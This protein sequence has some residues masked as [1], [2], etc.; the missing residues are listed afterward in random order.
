MESTVKVSEESKDLIVILKT[1]NEAYDA[2]GEYIDKY[3]G[4]D[5][6]SIRPI[7]DDFYSKWCEVVGVVENCLSSAMIQNLRDTNFGSI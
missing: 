2:F 6:T 4:K 5:N 1:L 7:G 3:F